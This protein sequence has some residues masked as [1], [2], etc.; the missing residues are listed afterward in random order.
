MIYLGRKILTEH[1]KLMIN[2]F[3]DT[4]MVIN[5][6]DLI[7]LEQC[8]AAAESEKDN[9]LI[10]GLLLGFC[11]AGGA[12]PPRA[13]ASFAAGKSLAPVSPAAC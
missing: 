12:A 10:L 11:R 13:P 2:Q 8:C 4:S 6:T 9:R 5:A 1:R 7:Y 3:C